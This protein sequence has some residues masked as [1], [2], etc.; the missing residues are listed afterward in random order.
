MTISW[1]IPMTTYSEMNRKEHWQVKHR[2]H[3]NQ[4][5][6]IAHTFSSIVREPITLPCQV[7]LTRISSQKLDDDNL[8]CAFKHIRDELAECILPDSKGSYLNAR[9]KIISIKGRGD[10]DDRIKWLYRQEKGKI[11]GIRITITM[12]PNNAS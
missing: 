7:T 1:Q 5:L 6:L 11:K 4:Q 2:R 8:M 9:G 12:E 10:A 3:K